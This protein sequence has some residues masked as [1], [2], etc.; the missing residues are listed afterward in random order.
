MHD[1]D[2]E[3]LVAEKSAVVLKIPGHI[4]KRKRVNHGDARQRI[5]IPSVQCEYLT[6]RVGSH[7]RGNAGVMNSLAGYPA[8]LHQVSPVGI[9][10]VGLRQSE[11]RPFYSPENSRSGV[12]AKSQSII[13]D[14]PC[15][16]CPKF[17]QVLTGH[18]HS[19][20]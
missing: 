11:R 3:P 10:A 15:A 8:G 7:S 12:W 20:T 1:S 18:T 2:D 14:R 6:D 5:K 13:R 19:M 17:D 9:N 4:S 16:D